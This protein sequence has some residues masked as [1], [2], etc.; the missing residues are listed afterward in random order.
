[1]EFLGQLWNIN[2]FW[3]LITASLVSVSCALLGCF[4]VLRKMAMVGDA[5]AH[6]VLPGIVIA[7]LISGTFSSIP[8]VV[9]ASIFGLFCA[10]LIEFLRTKGNVQVDASI[11]MVFTFLFAI[12][13]ILIAYYAG[14]VDLDQDCV[15]HGELAFVPLDTW[16]TAAGTDMGPRPVWILGGLLV[17]VL[18]LII[19]GYKGLFLTT[20]DPD[21]AQALGV[22][23]QHWHFVLMGA[24]SLAT[25]V[26][27]E[28]VGAVLVVAFL[29][30]PAATAYLLTNDLK[31]ML[32]L[33]S[34]IGVIASTFGYLLAVAIDGSI[35]GAIATVIGIIFFIVFLFSPLD[36]VIVKRLRKADVGVH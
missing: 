24:V 2:S 11:G 31:K 27:F 22:R 7:F 9:G 34:L 12:G 20:F 32:L 36:G 3:I 21:F 33:S 14:N 23:T 5:I 17:L 1:M 35:A 10:V 30:G 25:V 13:V 16:V 28:S 4:L 6:A 29:I 19:I 15:L 8:V 26:C 18:S